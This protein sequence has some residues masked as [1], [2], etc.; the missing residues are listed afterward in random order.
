MNPTH[1]KFTVEK[2]KMF[3]LF[4]YFGPHSDKL[5]AEIEKIMGKYF[6]KLN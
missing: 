1:E 4:P 3:A 2:H 5:V 6:P